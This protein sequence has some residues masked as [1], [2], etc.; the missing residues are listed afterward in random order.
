MTSDELLAAALGTTLSDAER[1]YLSLH[2]ELKLHYNTAI[3]TRLI[4]TEYKGSLLSVSA[5]AY[6]YLGENGA[7]VTWYP[8]Q[9]TLLDSTLPMSPMGDSYTASFDGVSEEDGLSVSVIFEASFV[10][11]GE[12]IAPLVNKAYRDAAN[13]TT[14]LE[15]L[16]KEYLSLKAEYDNKLSDYNEYLTRVSEFELN[17]AKY[18]EYLRAKKLYDDALAEYTRYLSELSEY[19]KTLAEYDN[20]EINLA[21]YNEA[22]ALYRKY[23]SDLAG[24]ESAKLEYSTYV[25]KMEQVTSQLSTLALLKKS[26]GTLNCYSAIMG[27]TVTKVLDNKLVLTDNSVGAS[28]ETIDRAY[29]ATNALRDLMPKYF[30]LKNDADRYSFY[31]IHYDEFR[32][33]I[34][35]LL[36]SLDELYSNK[37]VRAMIKAEEKNA[38]FVSL[39]ALLSVIARGLTDGPVRNHEGTAFTDSY[40]IDGST[41]TKILNGKITFTDTDSAAPLTEGYPFEVQEPKAPAEVKEPTKPEKVQKPAAPDS[42]DDP[43]EAPETVTEPIRP[44]TVLHPGDE[45]IEY[46]PPEEIENLTRAYKNGLLCAR[47]ELSSDFVYTAGCSVKKTVFGGSTVT[48]LFTDECENE[49]YRDEIERGS[50]VDFVG[51]LP[52]REEDAMATYTFIGWTAEKGSDLIFDLSHIDADGTLRLYPIFRANIKSYEI[53]FS[54]D[55]TEYKQSVLYGDLPRFDGTP[56]KEAEA[57]FDY[58]FSGWD[59]PITAVNSSKTYTAVFER[60]YLVPLPGGGATVSDRGEY[61]EVDDI[62]LAVEKIDVYYLLSRAATLGKGVIIKSAKATLT[63]S[64]SNVLELSGAGLCYIDARSVQVGTSGYRY[65]VDLYD[66]DMHKLTSEVK[67]D[68]SFPTA[69]TEPNHTVLYRLSEQSEKLYVRCTLK[70]GSAGFI[71]NTGIDYYLVCEYNVSVIPSD[72]LELSVSTEISPFGGYVAVKYEAPTGYR[73]TRVYYLTPDGSEVEIGDG[74]FNMPAGD[75]SVGAEYERITYKV[76]FI[77]AGKVIAVHTYYYGDTVSAPSDPTKPST[78]TVSYSFT[79]WFPLV[80]TVSADAT[81]TAQFKAHLLPPTTT[82]GPGITSDVLGLLVGAAVGL[83]IFILGMIPATVIFFVERMRYKR[84]FSS[85]K[86]AKKHK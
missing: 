67:M 58:I 7:S 22:Y 42:V 14:E 15:R 82:G 66:R 35:K 23:L 10:I 45:P 28:P 18:T 60:R 65:R 56:E 81:Y 85:S 49:L 54:V 13:Y 62:G 51:S 43:G 9:V 5:L 1:E 86:R 6:T 37:R 71:L 75:V 19:E 50:L 68:V 2:G 48:V 78:D 31:C 46:I 72:V 39:V 41:V 21:A 30:A 26:N 73:I 16:N 20:Y 53:I 63:L 57:S 12:D 69:F 29:E 38:Q 83:G 11:S 17:L 8:R 3:P 74:Y 84:A 64:Y 55:G 44:D 59:S 76:T 80:E 25:S 40:K 77:S 70:D 61:L 4:T 33:N 34:T 24:Y 52:T 32:D 47:E 79:G 36:V 27:P